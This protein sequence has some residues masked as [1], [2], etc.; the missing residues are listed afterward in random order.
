MTT[1]PRVESVA[2]QLHAADEGERPDDYYRRLAIDVLA[3][4]DANEI[5]YFTEIR[6]L[7]ERVTALIA[8]LAG[9]IEFGDSEPEVARDYWIEARR[10]VESGVLN[11]PGD[12]DEN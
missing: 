12:H 6:E 4:A 11:E 2:Q 9:L 3:T 5:A 1:D 8:A 10:V 7:R